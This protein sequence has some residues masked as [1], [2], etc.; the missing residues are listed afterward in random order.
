MPWVDPVPFS[1][2]LNEEE[3]VNWSFVSRYC[4]CISAI[5]DSLSDSSYT[6]ISGNKRERKK[7]VYI[8]IHWCCC[9]SLLFNIYI[10][11]YIYVC[12]CVCVWVCVCEWKLNQPSFGYYKFIETMVKI[13]FSGCWCGWAPV[14]KFFCLLKRETNTKGLYAK[15]PTRPEEDEERQGPRA[16]NRREELVTVRER[17]R[18]EKRSWDLWTQKPGRPAREDESVFLIAVWEFCSDTR[19]R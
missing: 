15:F 17:R 4:L 12:V 11:I 2:K 10:Y 9:P 16:V 6:Y 13:R 19:S 1:L 7:S 5:L 8:F 14:R 3:A 18:S